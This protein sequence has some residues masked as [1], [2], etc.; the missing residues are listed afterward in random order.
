MSQTPERDWIYLTPNGEKPVVLTKRQKQVL[1][2]IAS[3]YRT[4]EIAYELGLKPETVSMHLRATRKK[5]GARTN[6]QAV[7]ISRFA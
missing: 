1:D 4:K 7:K 5:L 2:L 3:G 6:A